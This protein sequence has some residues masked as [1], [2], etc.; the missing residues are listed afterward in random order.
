MSLT[1]IGAPD[2][3]PVMKLPRVMARKKFL[4]LLRLMRY[5]R[6]ASLKAVFAC[7]ECRQVVKLKRGEGV[8]EL[9]GPASG[10]NEKRDT[11]SLSCDCTVWTVNQ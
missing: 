1:L 8:I 7:P 9:A 4:K 11:F 5:A 6:E 10:V 2:R 3:T